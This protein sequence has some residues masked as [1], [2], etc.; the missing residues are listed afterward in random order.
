MLFRSEGRR[1]RETNRDER[2]KMERD[3]Q[4]LIIMNKSKANDDTQLEE[5]TRII[6][7]R[8]LIKS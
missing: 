6:S 4:R 5:R 2:K 7:W 1:W 8:N 3:K